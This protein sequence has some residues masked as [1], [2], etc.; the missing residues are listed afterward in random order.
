M[1]CSE[2]GRIVVKSVSSTG[3]REIL[4]Q[5]TGTLQALAHSV[6]KVKKG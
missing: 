5:D 2:C 6:Y 1:C 4:A 3:A